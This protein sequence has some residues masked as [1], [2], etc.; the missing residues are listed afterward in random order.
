MYYEVTICSEIAPWLQGLKV[1]LLIWAQ[2]LINIDDT[3][4]LS[5]QEFNTRM[6][7]PDVGEKLPLVQQSI[8][9]PA[10]V[11]SIPELYALAGVDAEVLTAHRY[12]Q[13]NIARQVGLADVEADEAP[14][15][16][17]TRKTVTEAARV[18]VLARKS[19]MKGLAALYNTVLLTCWVR[20]L[21]HVPST[22]K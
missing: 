19:K 22:G 2:Y 10:M 8:G 11:T 5:E 1:L 21:S 6:Q 12:S 20:L 4:D 9:L 15:R 17:A 16:A 3:E 14:T 18:S 13:C 7:M